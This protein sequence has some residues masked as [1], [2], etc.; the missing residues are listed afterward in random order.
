MGSL[1]VIHVNFALDNVKNPWNTSW[2]TPKIPVCD[3]VMG[4]MQQSYTIAACDLLCNYVIY[5]KEDS[6]EL[7]SH[8][9]FPY[10]GG[11]LLC[12]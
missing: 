1:H 2:N 12:K 7:G 6:N 8:I 10:I 5:I 3:Y 4:H 9:K 11:E